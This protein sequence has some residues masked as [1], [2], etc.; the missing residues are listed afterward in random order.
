MNDIQRVI[1][2][3]SKRLKYE[4]NK[5]DLDIDKINQLSY[6]IYVLSESLVVYG[7]YAL[8]MAEESCARLLDP[9]GM[10]S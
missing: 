10:H 6:E 8:D 3:L 5:R 7:Q 9:Q 1:D 2:A 4:A